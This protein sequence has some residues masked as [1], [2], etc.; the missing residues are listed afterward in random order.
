MDR[1]TYFDISQF[2]D[3]PYRTMI[4]GE[5][6]VSEWFVDYL[7]DCDLYYWDGERVFDYV[8]FDYDPGMDDTLHLHHNFN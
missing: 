8:D 3:S 2:P 5:H 1:S 4:V 7:S 6:F